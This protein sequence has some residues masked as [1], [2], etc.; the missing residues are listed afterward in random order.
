M[1]GIAGLYNVPGTPDEFAA[2]SFIN[3]AHHRDINRAIYNLLNVTIEEFVLDP[4][5]IREPGVWLYQHQLMHQRQNALLGIDGYN[6]LDVDLT[7]PEELAG[8]IYA[9]SNE[10]QQ[11]SDILRIG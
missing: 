2:W 4:F 6:L 7:K 3:M 9:H 1:S 10:H 5:N 11:A 8:W